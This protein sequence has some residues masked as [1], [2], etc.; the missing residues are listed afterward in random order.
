MNAIPAGNLKSEESIPL[1]WDRGGLP[2]WTYHNEE[3][4]E[5]EKE[6]LFRRHWQ[7]A[8]HVSDIPE[9]GDYVTFDMVGERAVLMRG[10]DGQIQAF[11]NLC[12]HRGSRVLCESK[13]NCKRAIVCPF[14]GWS[15]GLDGSLLGATSPETLPK[16]DSIEHGLKPI[17]FEI[18]MGFVFVR[19][20][21][22]DQP[23]VAEL[24]A[25]HAEEIAHYK[26]ETMVPI[27]S[28]YWSHDMEVNWK[29]VRDVDNEGYHVKI[30]HPELQELYGGNY[31]DEPLINGSCRSYAEFTDTP[32]K[33]WSVQKY[34]KILPKV[35]HLPEKSQR[36]WL[37]IGIYPNMVLSFYPCT[38]SFYQEFPIT[39][40][41]THQRGA[42]YR[43]QDESRDMRLAR[44]LSTRIDNETTDEDTQLI[45]WS[46]EAMNSSAF[47]GIVLSDLEY[48]VRGY[49]DCFRRDLPVMNLEQP[50]APNTVKAM[51]A[52]MREI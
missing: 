30:A 39:A 37:Y 47:D 22:G 27:E 31:S 40:G 11:H 14:H 45:E 8:C 7:V 35:P 10:K 18:W 50:P 28:N 52:Q 6:V 25:R 1:D 13:G 26:S 38:V 12:R 51:N 42:I 20:L 44:Y 32:G 21:P 48:N 16:L 23:P 15:Y 41:K 2:G 19:F 29:S 36:A 3:L 4:T 5:L 24:L 17:E 49:H 46:C 33:I 43:H 34:K 9:S